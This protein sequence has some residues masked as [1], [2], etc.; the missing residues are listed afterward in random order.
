MVRRI[1]HELMNDVL[2]ALENR[3]LTG[4]QIF[5]MIKDR[6]HHLSRKLVYHYLSLALKKGDIKVEKVTE[7]GDFSWGKTTEKKYYTKNY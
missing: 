4:Y 7:E 1:N 5:G 2:N 3:R 6:Y